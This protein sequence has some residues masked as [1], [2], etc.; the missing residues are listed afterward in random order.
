MYS[1]ISHS[2]TIIAFIE[3][4]NRFE[5]LTSI[6]QVWHSTAELRWHVPCDSNEV[7]SVVR[8]V[9][10]DQSLTSLR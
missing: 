8:R 4:P 2:N 5:L 9:T 3:P 1:T 7:L 6:L 10:R